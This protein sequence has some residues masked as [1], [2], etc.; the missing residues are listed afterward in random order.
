MNPENPSSDQKPDSSGASKTRLELLDE[1]RL[2]QEKLLQMEADSRS[3]KERNRTLARAINIGYWEWDE[4]TKRSAYFSEEMAGILG[5]S[6]ESLYETYLS[7]EDFYHSVHPEDLDHYISNL[8]T[9]LDLDYPRDVAHT[10]DY[11]IVRPDG[12]VRY[13]R[14]L[15]YGTQEKDGVVT[16]S[17]G[18]I[19][20]ITVHHES[21]RA[22]RESEQRYGSLFSKLPLGVMEQDWS[23]IKKGVDK[24]RSEGVENLKAYLINNPVVL[25]ELVATVS[26]KSVNEAL[27]KIYGAESA[28]EYI[29]EEENSGDWLDE[30]WADLYASEIAGLAG[31]E[32][33][34]YAELTETR[35]DDSVFQTR[36][37]TS[38]VRGDEDS[39]NRVITI[40]EDVTERKQQEIALSKSKQ[41]YGSLF[42]QMPLG[43]LEQDY[44]SLKQGIDKLRSQGVENIREYLEANGGFLQEL[45]IGANVTAANEKLLK[46]YGVETLQE[47]REDDRNVESWWS[48]EW[49]K[50]YASEIEGLLSPDNLNI[51]ELKE[52]RA[53]GSLFEVRMTTKAV[54]GC[55]DSWE[56]IITLHEDITEQKLNEI[57]LIEAKEAAEQASK[58]KSE[59]LATMSHE[60]R[61]PMNGVLGMTELLIDTGLDMRAQRLAITAHR[62]A[63]SL[64]EIIN[65]ILDFSKIEADKMELSEEDF[66]LREVL[67]DVLEMIAGQAHR[68]GLECIGNLPP[69]LPRQVRGDAMRLRQVM[70][71]LLGNAVKF[72]ERGEIRLSATVERRNVDS[73]QMVFEISDTGPGIPLENQDSIFNAFDQ[74][75]SSASRRF[76]GTG[77]GL[78]IT[79]R[80]VDLMAGRIE[81]ESTP[82]NG[83]LFRLNIPLDV[84]NNDITQPKPPEAL[85]GLRIL[86]VDDHPTNREILHNQVISWGMRNDNV[87]SAV[88]AIEYIRV[89]QAENDP[90]QIV[91]LD[92]HMPDM[93]GLELARNLTTDPSIRTPQLVL[94]SSTG[95]DSRSTIAKKASIAA[96]LQKP[97]RQQLLL[98]CLCEVLGMKK[99]GNKTT[100]AEDRQFEGE[101]LLAE[102]NEVNQEVAIGMLMLLGCNADLAENGSAA[103]IA[104]KGKRYDLILMDCHMPE[105]NGFEASRKLREHEEQRGL[106]RTPIVAL[107]ADVKKGIEDECAEAGMDGYLSK[108]FSKTK[109]E[110]LLGQWL[111]S[112]KSVAESSTELSVAVISPAEKI[113]DIDVLNQLKSLSE[114]TGR[115]ILGKS[116]RFFLRQTPDDVASLLQAAAQADLETVRN[117]AHSLKSSSA[118]LGAMGFSRLCN[119]IE[120]SAREG[121]I[122][123]ALAQLPEV[124]AML[125]QLLYE[126]RQQAGIDGSVELD[127]MEPDQSPAKTSA[128]SIL[129]VDDD[130]G[131]RLTTSE[132]L[133][134]T[135]F[136]VIEASSGEAALSIL[137]ETVPDLVLLDAIMPSIDGFEVCT[138][139]R[140]RRETRSI[141]VMILT[142]LG[143]MESVNKAFESGATDFIVKPV[144]YSVLSS[145]IRFQL[146]VAENLKE[147]N[148]SKEWLASAQR[149]AGVGYWQWDSVNDRITVS[150]QLVEMLSLENASAFKNLNDF[151]NFVHPQDQEF[152][153]SKILSVSLDGAT[154]SDDYRLVTLQ[155]ETIV[156]HQELAQPSNSSDIV[157]GTVQDVTLQRESERKIRQLAYSDELTGL[158]SRVYFHTHLEDVIKASHRRSERFA[159]LFLDL[160]GFKD[161][162]DSLGHDVGDMLLKIV[163]KR[164]QDLIRDTDFVARL[165]GDEFCILVDNIDDQY[166]AAYVA[167]RC[168]EEMN[169][170]INLGGQNIR[171]RCSI[172]IAYYPKDGEDSQ[173]LLKAADSAMYAAKEAGKHRYVYYQPEFTEK[174]EERL[175][176]EQELRLTIDN[177][178]LELHY[179]PQ[180][181]LKTGRMTGVEALVRWNHP[182]RGMVA[183]LEFI[184]IAERI[185]FTKPLGEWVLKTACQQAMAWRDMGLPELQLAVNI[186]A[187]HFQ[188]ADFISMV[189]K[190]LEDSGFPA[191]LL[192]LE[193]TESVTQPTSRN[194]SIFTRLRKMGIRIAIDDFGTGYSS[195]ASLKLL[196]IDCLKI[197]RLFIKDMLQ[198]PESSILLGTII[199]AAHALGHAVVAEGVE[200]D[201]QVKVLTAIGSDFI[202]GFYFSKPVA[203]RAIPDLAKTDFITGGSQSEMMLPLQQKKAL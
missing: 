58:A 33:I 193:V 160:D 169:E 53:D 87:D 112:D 69:E 21:M 123:T 179:Q 139:I 136:N 178:E 41:R 98:D 17:F 89:A 116:A 29:A 119:Q 168:L 195:L 66:D 181:D 8:S 56:R 149:I 114:T 80:L 120:D 156:V 108:P 11:R 28:E 73:F 102:D 4:E 122:E 83:T 183:P 172:G 199:G 26:I 118:N 55:E 63:E 23:V 148:I 111:T 88:K 141:P 71:N 100:I 96:H 162:N 7:E 145:R 34:N 194:I 78:A 125:P 132:A 36:L 144:N 128:P 72:T 104:A 85:V 182:T 52:E 191:S 105:M 45:V 44:S 190:T 127:E 95:F 176:I 106:P 130:N 113:I 154:S 115:D 81:L 99:S 165:S 107:T 77:L 24:L 74:V 38:I 40:V 16:R 198:N 49:V 48:D 20:D 9:V 167:E 150:E 50:F 143:D 155:S 152:I 1:N 129:V 171:T 137:E 164:L 35:M 31:P 109:L 201:D 147:L 15:E 110:A 200:E 158:A 159:L 10:F 134:G 203:A 54:R 14:E 173:S 101:V 124:E 84:A 47:F 157:L 138:Q 5:M 59:F 151:L 65:D 188:D 62:S 92:W 180:I 18:A 163:A 202:Q 170:P 61:T 196:P 174:A 6:L 64:L 27:L 175:R 103:V 126:L 67:E 32:R 121:R 51:A 30:E 161:V 75:D 86:V 97:V 153:R 12:E 94:L 13:V 142:G 43:V 93:D 76:G 42:S 187:S 2:L 90:Y 19:Q 133:K 185:G 39:W 79:G 37:I 25:R 177:D 197:D 117:I 166:G 3:E 82:G 91:L 131:F 135:G 57:A 22:A 192:E 189:E 60:I 184:D 70:V 186:S 46:L 68:K 140:K 146:R